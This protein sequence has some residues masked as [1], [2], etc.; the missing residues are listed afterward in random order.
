MA[1]PGRV[2]WS[3]GYYGGLL[4]VTLTLTFATPR[5]HAR[6]AL[7]CSDPRVVQEYLEDELTELGIL[8][9]TSIQMLEG[10]PPYTLPYPYQD[11]SLDRTA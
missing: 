8:L 5:E 6:S 7:F 9:I 1:A 2:G 4:L 3:L 11:V 10:R